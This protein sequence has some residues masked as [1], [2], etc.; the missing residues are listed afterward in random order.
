MSRVNRFEHLDAASLKPPV[1]MDNGFLKVEG[2][3]ARVGIQEY[4][5]ADGTVER[6]LR[7]PEEVFHPDSLASFQQVP[8]TN[9][10]PP[11]MLTAKNAK[12]YSVGSVGEN[13]RQDGEFVA[14]PL[15]ITDSDAI[16]SI[17]AGR[18]Q[19]S[20]GYSCRLDYTKKPELVKQYG[21]YD[22]SQHDIRGNH[23][24]LVDLARAG[25]GASIRLDEGDAMTGE[26]C[27]SGSNML[28]SSPHEGDRSMPIKIKLDGFDIEVAD[29]NAQSIIERAI[30]KARVDG[31]ATFEAEKVRADTAEKAKGDLAKSISELSAKVDSLEAKAKADADETIKINGQDMKLTELRDQAKF[32]AAILPLVAKAGAARGALVTLA[33]QHLGAN[34]KLDGLSDIEIKKLVIKKLDKDIKL[35]GKDETYIFHRFDFETE[36]AAKN[37]VRPIDR[38]RLVQQDPPAGHVDSDPV[39]DDPDEVRKQMIARLDSQNVK[40]KK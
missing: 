24:A 3:I 29:S 1:R 26:F 39:S 34:E 37:Q 27:S 4:R 33:T 20:N 21:E 12:Q 11:G 31:R 28:V 32:D 8:V 17:E 14:A 18:S 36:K 40:V 25:S 2:R 19:L 23:C 13:V 16:A 30:E 6:E 10:H 38:V 35:D 7:I 22:A 9:C 5:R 15:M